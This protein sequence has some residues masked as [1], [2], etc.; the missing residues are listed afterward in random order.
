MHPFIIDAKGSMFVDVASAT[1][2][3]QVKNRQPKIPGADPCI[4]LET[5]GGV[6]RL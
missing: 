5:R 4:E 6:W 1:N 2:A 3:C